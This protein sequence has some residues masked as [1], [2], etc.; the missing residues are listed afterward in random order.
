[1][2]AVSAGIGVIGG[3]V[4]ALCAPAEQ[5]VVVAPGQG[6]ALTGESLHRFDSLALLACISVIVGVVLPVAFWTWRSRRGPV[7]YLGLLIGTVVGSAI[8]VGLGV[9]IAGLVH[10]RPDDP[11]VGSVVAVAPGMES[12]LVLTITP[13]VMSLVVVLLAAMNPHDNLIDTP[14]E[15]TLDV[16][17]DASSME[18]D[19]A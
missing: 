7:L 17:A 12:P 10:S 16:A 8:T 4:W 13:L 15:H 19:H 6:A 14:D 1:M 2:A 9:W 5:F 11:E 3:V 18:S